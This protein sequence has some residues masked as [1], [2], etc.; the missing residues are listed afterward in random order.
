LEQYDYVIVGAGS[1]GAVLA[2]RLTENPRTR[3]LLLEAGRAGHFYSRFPISYGLL[4]HHP[5][6]NWLYESAPEAGTA[7]RRIPVPRGKLLGGSSAINGLI[8]CAASR[9]TTTPGRGWARMAGAGRTW[10]RCSTASRTSSGKARPDA[11]AAGRCT[12]PSCRIGTRFTTRSWR[13]QS[14]S[15]IASIPTTTAGIKRVSARL[16]RAS[17]A[18]AE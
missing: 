2:V 1:A 6:A 12:S 10:R 17:G 11:G 4:I 7:N 5:A 14:R 15:A 8:W 13:G 3:V 9:S 16:R 18:A